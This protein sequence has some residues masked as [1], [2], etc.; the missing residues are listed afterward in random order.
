MKTSDFDYDL[1]PEFIAQTPAEP[2]DSSRLMILSRTNGS[3]SH[4]RFHELDQLLNDSDVLVFNDSRVLPARLSGKKSDTGGRV[5]ILLLRRLGP[6]LWESLVKP[7]RRV[8]EGVKIEFDGLSGEVEEQ[9]K[10]A[11]RV[12][13]FSDEGALERA[14]QVPLPPY[15][16]RP[17]DDPERYQTIYSRV[18]GSAAAPTAG[19]HFTPELLRRLEAKGVQFAF[20]TLHVGLDTF[21]PVR[22]DDP[23]E[24]PIHRE[25]GELAPQTAQRLNKAKADGRR[26]I[27]V[28]TT[29]ARLL[30]QASING[31]GIE[32]FCDWSELL[33]L[34]G[35]RFQALDA[36]ITNF[37]L[38]R[39]TLIMLVAAFTGQ[40][41]THRAYEEAKRQ[42][43][44]FY[45]F[46]DA[47]LIV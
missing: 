20:L 13:R 5:E 15:I 14:G 46:G 8:G 40:Q 29:T 11:L 42:G 16:H 23:G 45:S 3:I 39:T 19:L 37:H 28:G 25:Y 35:H 22:A 17:L 7:S 1:P 30:E 47:M 33:I 4:H 2:R 27:G 31:N 36:M 38:P 26:I 21:A 44:R 43:Y 10:G 32:P 18:S 6:G 12:I 24:H 9:K 41:F 34:P